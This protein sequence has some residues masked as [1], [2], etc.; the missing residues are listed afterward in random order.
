[1]ILSCFCFHPFLDFYFNLAPEKITVNMTNMT[2]KRITEGIKDQAKQAAIRTSH[3]SVL[4]QVL[5]FQPTKEWINT[6]MK[7]IYL[8]VP[9][10]L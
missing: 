5:H 7:P 1:M 9:I 8:K 6:M 4:L 3:A 2:T 10:T